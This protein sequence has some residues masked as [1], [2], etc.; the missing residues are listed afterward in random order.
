METFLIIHQ[1][2]LLQRVYYYYSLFYLNHRTITGSV[3]WGPITVFE[4]KS[5]INRCPNKI[6]ITISRW[7]VSGRETSHWFVG[8]KNWKT[9][10]YFQRFL[11]SVSTVS[12]IKVGNISSLLNT[13]PRI[14]KKHQKTP[15]LMLWKHR[16]NLSGKKRWGCLVSGTGFLLLVP[17]LC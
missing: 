7:K 5:L 11:Q 1:Q 16:A 12:A 13:C 14:K 3:N 10:V 8:F 17:K 2:L 9:D 4:V 6:T 15:T